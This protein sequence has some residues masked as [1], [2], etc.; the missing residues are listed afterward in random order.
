ME[1]NCRAAADAGRPQEI[2]TAVLTEGN[3][4]MLNERQEAGNYGASL[5][6][7][8]VTERF[9][10]SN[11]RPGAGSSKPICPSTRSS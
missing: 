7:I 3:A 1:G 2:C 9:L 6:G 5:C 4:Q 10:I 8:G 11:S